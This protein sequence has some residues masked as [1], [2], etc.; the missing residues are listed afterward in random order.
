MSNAPI[1]FKSSL[2][3][4]L[5]TLETP[6]NKTKI[7]MYRLPQQYLPFISSHGKVPKRPF[8]EDN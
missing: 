7:L 6:F 3:S 8:S 2:N 4:K 5:T 1:E